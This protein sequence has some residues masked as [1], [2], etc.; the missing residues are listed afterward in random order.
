[1][2]LLEI[3]SLTL[4][5][6]VAVLLI[7]PVDCGRPLIWIVA[8]APLATVPSWHVTVPLACEQVPCEGV[9]ESKVIPAGSV[10]VTT[11]PVAARGP[12]LPTVSV[13]GDLLAD[14]HRI[15]R[16]GLGQREVGVQRRRV[17]GDRVERPAELV[18][19]RDRHRGAAD[20]HEQEV[21]HA[22][23]GGRDRPGAAG[24]ADV[25]R[26]STSRCRTRRSGRSRRWPRSTPGSRRRRR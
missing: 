14:E 2:L 13:V 10:S 7:V 26:G 9:A 5:E 24:A 1:M 21:V 20:A 8:P 11:V 23:L 4:E 25:G 3:G 16:V 19:R 22:V 6:T 12:A 17:V 15:G 18:G